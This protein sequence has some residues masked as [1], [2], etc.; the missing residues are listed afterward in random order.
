MTVSGPPL[1][2]PSQL[3]RFWELHPQT[4]HTW[5]VQG[6]LPA[7]R[8][9][10]NHFRVR[11]AEVKAFCERE[12]LPVP[13]FVAP[14]LPRVI[15]AA[16][17]AAIRRAVARALRPSATVDVLD[18]PYAAIVAAVSGPT[19]V[20]AM[21]ASAGRFDVT[22]AVRALKGER[23]TEGIAIVVFGVTARPL[24]AALDRAGADRH[25]LLAHA[26]ALPDVLRELLGLGP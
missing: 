5:I 17:P 1:V 13:P 3:A 4:V 24:G 18:D 10:G 16:A 25:V 23:A 8:S 15:V 26:A 19:A 6:R 21:G 9:P 12:S 14:T 11:A 2:R 7:I 20:L 22:A